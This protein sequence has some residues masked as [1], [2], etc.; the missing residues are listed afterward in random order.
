MVE[1][2]QSVAIMNNIKGK[3]GYLHNDDI[4]MLNIL[5]SDAGNLVM[6]DLDRLQF[7]NRPEL[8]LIKILLKRIIHRDMINQFIEGYTVHRDTS[9]LIEMCEERKWRWLRK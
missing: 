4:T 6:F 8:S 9:A 3:A 2:G 1:L 5:W 7:I